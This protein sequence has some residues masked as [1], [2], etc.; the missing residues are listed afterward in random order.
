MSAPTL[1]KVRRIGEPAAKPAY[2]VAISIGPLILSGLAAAGPVYQPPGANLVLGDVT[3]AGRVQS[4]SS[5]P[6]AAAAERA[7]RKDKPVGGTVISGA[8]GLEYGNIQN[9]FDYYDSVTGAYKPSDP[10]EGGGGPG[11]LPE[12][13]P[14]GIDLG[15]IWDNLDPDVQAAVEAVAAE[16]ATQTALLLAIREEGYGK[17]WLAADAPFVVASEYL[18][19]TWTFEVSWSGSSKAFGIA[20]DIE[21]DRAAARE[22]L[23][24]WFN[25]LPINRPTLLPVS[26]HILLTVDPENNGVLL[27]IDNDSSI[28]TKSTRTTELNAGYSRPVG[29][30]KSGSLFLGGEAR[31]YLKELSRLSVRFGDITNTE[32]LF[33]AIRDNDFRSDTGVGID[34][35]ALW[36]GQNFQLGAQVTNLNEPTFKFPDVNLDPY[37]DNDVIRFLRSD[38]KYKAD[39]QLKLEASVFS[40]ERRWSAHLGY[41]ADPMTDPM[42]D[43]FQWLTLSAGFTTDS[44]WLPSWRIGYRRNLAGTELSYVG[45]GVTAFKFLNI[46]VSSALD[47]TIIDG[48]KLPQGLMGSI[49]FQIVW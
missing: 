26:D 8:A 7:R 4:A 28:I 30:Y 18:G 42:G 24:D 29:V 27:S 40:Q 11:Q 39:R 13:K 31:L 3:H 17:A 33:D 19:G 34:V 38:K 45:I 6:A 14:G 41:D 23:E 12:N 43:R 1:K 49:G 2:R 46:D 35:G 21:F 37:T 10:D 44:W 22:A 47:T 32:E 25:T 48:T 15:Q 20:T 36:V 16:V 5:N 9:L